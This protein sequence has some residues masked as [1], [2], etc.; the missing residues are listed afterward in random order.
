M[1]LHSK[2]SLV[3][4]LCVCA[5]PALAQRSLPTP[6][7]PPVQ[8]PPPCD[9]FKKNEDIDWVTKQD[10]ILPRPNG[11]AQVKAGTVVDEALQDE[12]DDRCKK[13]PRRGQAPARW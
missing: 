7:Q 12:L 9:A 8:V 11:P 2:S 1:L 13:C 4:V 10:M 5:V 6:P 3:L